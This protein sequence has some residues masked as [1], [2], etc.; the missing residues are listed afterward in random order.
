MNQFHLRYWMI[1][2]RSL[3]DTLAPNFAT[4]LPMQPYTALARIHP[5]DATNNPLPALTRYVNV[6]P[7]DIPTH[8][9]GNNGRVIGRDGHPL[10]GPGGEDLSYEKFS[11]DIGPGQTWDVTYDWHDVEHWNPTSNPVPVTMP[12]ELNLTYGMLYSGSPYLGDMGAMPPG[13]F[14]MNQCG[15]YYIISHSHALYQVTAWGQG[16]TMMGLATFLRVDPPLPNSCP[17]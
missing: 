8:P 7:L 5:Y 2:G 17:N 3:P 11:M 6:V 4:W 12:S 14:S 10:Q 13:T 9:H 1:N 15:E 16:L